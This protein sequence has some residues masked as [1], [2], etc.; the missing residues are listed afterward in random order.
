MESIFEK[1]VTLKPL[2]SSSTQSGIDKFLRSRVEGLE[3]SDFDWINTTQSKDLK[4]ISNA[5][6]GLANS[7]KIN[8]ILRVNRFLEKANRCLKNGDYLLVCMET[9]NSRRMNL[10]NKYPRIISRIYYVF[11]FVIKRIFP[12][13]KVTKKIYF[14]ITKGKNRVISLSEGLGR[15][16]SCGFKIV[17]YQRI[18]YVTYILSQKYSEPVYDM[19][20]TY[21]PLIRLKRVGKGGRLF[22]VYKMRT[23]HP[24]S[25]YL[26][27]YIF[28]E[29]N[30]QEGGKIRDD[31]RV[32][33][34]GKL[35]RKLWIDEIPMLFNFIKGI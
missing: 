3:K 27:D 14:W 28:N 17:G 5:K 4:S 33:S 16:V 18:G 25:E 30:L 9:K 6:Y 31:F 29:N 15:L 8:D 26:Q 24:Y 1:K 13:W 19:Q 7:H 23:M 12:K 20:P 2:R 11:D 34:W 10:L 21:G 32:T 22:T 35:F